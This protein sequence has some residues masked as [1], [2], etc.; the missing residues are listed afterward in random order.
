MHCKYPYSVIHYEGKWMY[1]SCNCVRVY[2][3]SPNVCALSGESEE[4]NVF[5]R[6]GFSSTNCKL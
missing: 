5:I 3:T 2:F 1:A 6:G 4:T